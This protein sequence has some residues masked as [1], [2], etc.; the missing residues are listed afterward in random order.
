MVRVQ[1]PDQACSAL[2]FAL[3]SRQNLMDQVIAKLGSHIRIL[4]IRVM[5]WEWDKILKETPCDSSSQGGN[6]F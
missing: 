4:D 6:S 5:N 3:D 2:V 1:T